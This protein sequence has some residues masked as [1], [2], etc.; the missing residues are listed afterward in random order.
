MKYKK[1]Q[2]LEGKQEMTEYEKE[3]Q[4]GNGKRDM[5]GRKKRDRETWRDGRKGE[6]KMEGARRKGIKR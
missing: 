6:G 2:K 1:E 5:K 4:A 3:V